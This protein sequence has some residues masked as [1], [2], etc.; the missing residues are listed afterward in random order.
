LVN[1]GKW[2]NV[3]NNSDSVDIDK[4]DEN[5]LSFVK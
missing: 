4:K 3:D 2:I 5:N 1:V